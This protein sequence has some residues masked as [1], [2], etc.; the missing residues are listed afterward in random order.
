M[1]FYGAGKFWRSEFRGKQ[2]EREFVQRVSCTWLMVVWFDYVRTR[3][4]F[5]PFLALLG[6]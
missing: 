3:I 4:I 2:K 5:Q 6:V 1:M